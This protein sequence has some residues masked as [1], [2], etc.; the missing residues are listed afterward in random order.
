M[1]SFPHMRHIFKTQ[2]G[3]YFVKFISVFIFRRM[4]LYYIITELYVATYVYSMAV[5]FAAN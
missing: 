3:G 5:R 4:V 1:T 2:F